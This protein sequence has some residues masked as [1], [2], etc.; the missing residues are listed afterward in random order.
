MSLLAL[1]ILGDVTRQRRD[2]AKAE[3][4]YRQ[5][6]EIQQ[7]LAPESLSS[8]VTFEGLAEVAKEKKD[9]ASSEGYYRHALI[10]LGKLAPESRQHAES[11]ASLA[12]VMRQ[13]GELDLAS[14]LYEQALHTIENQTARLGG[15][16]D[17]RASFALRPE[18]KINLCGDI[19]NRL[20]SI[21]GR[22]SSRTRLWPVA[23][24]RVSSLSQQVFLNT[25]SFHPA[26]CHWLFNAIVQRT[27]Q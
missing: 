12:G 5:A 18:A 11:L 23:N 25:D 13:K 4:Y 7:K 26:S 17:V 9:L 22:P 6:F 3:G 1:T 24:L 10:I 19:A 20:S 2:L 27:S 14:Q 16:E 8:A 15:S 21:A